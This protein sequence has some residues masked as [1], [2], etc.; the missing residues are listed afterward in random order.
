MKQP[1]NPNLPENMSL[2]DVAKGAHRPPVRHDNVRMIV[3]KGHDYVAQTMMDDPKWLY[4][5]ELLIRG[6]NHITVAEVLISNAKLIIESR[7]PI[8]S[9]EQAFVKAA[10]K[11]LKEINREAT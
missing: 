3:T 1:K 8:G 2:H 4:D 5:R 7:N 6:Y 11:F 9:H 10:T